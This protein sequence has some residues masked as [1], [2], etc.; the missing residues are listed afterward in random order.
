[1]DADTPLVASSLN[2]WRTIWF[3]PRR[4]IRRIVDAEVRPSWVPVIALA[5]LHQAILSLE[6]DP[7]EG[8]LSLARSAVPVTVSVLQL[9]FGV[10]VG[11]FLLAFVGGWLGGE[12]D[13]AEIRQ[14][15]AWSHLPLAVSTACWIP[16]VAVYGWNTLGQNFAPDAAHQWL[17]LVVGLLM[18][19]AMVW[20]I[21]LQIVTL[22][23][24]QRFSI[25][26]ALASIII[27]VVP[28][29]LLGALLR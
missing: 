18:F 11:P 4:T 20:T 8:T 16:I 23:E 12:A 6:I 1:M 26:R 25:V 5:A 7:A 19:A 24:V 17:I 15:A 14:S 10:L 21:V 29:L 13:P 28:V 27:L 3:S 2:P 9:I 22:A